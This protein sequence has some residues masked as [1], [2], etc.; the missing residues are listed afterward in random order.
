[1][2]AG[3]SSMALVAGVR[4]EFHRSKTQHTCAGMM[5]CDSD[6]Q[7]AARQSKY[8]NTELV[9]NVLPASDPFKK[10]NAPVFINGRLRSS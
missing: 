2:V 10:V 9:S 7:S 3:E 5:K 4:V 8:E 1:M 6:P